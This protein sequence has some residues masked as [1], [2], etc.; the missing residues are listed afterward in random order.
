[1]L[2]VL[3]ARRRLSL[4]SAVALVSCA[5]LLSGCGLPR[6]LSDRADP[7]E[8]ASL[9]IC[10]VVP[11]GELRKDHPEV[12]MQPTVSIPSACV[13]R[14]GGDD[15]EDAITVSIVDSDVP[16][17]VRT[18]GGP[19]VTDEDVDG[20]TAVHVDN[21]EYCGS[22][23]L[24]DNGIWL[25]IGP[26]QSRGEPRAE[27]GCDVAQSIARSVVRELAS[28][29]PMIDWPEKSLFRKDICARAEGVELAPS[30]GV[31][32]E[33]TAH[34]THLTCSYSAAGSD[35][36]P[37]NG[38]VVSVVIRGEWREPPMPDR[39]RLT[40]AGHVA[41]LDDTQAGGSRPTGGALCRFEIDFGHNPEVDRRHRSDDRES[42]S[43]SLMTRGPYG[44][45]S[46]LPAIT[47]LVES[48]D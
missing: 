45:E 41:E 2:T 33:V 1:M 30:L 42:L 44:C 19:G 5:L 3:Y 15:D 28:A 38:L 8:Y 22:Y 18:R 6:P 11:I 36:G 25:G 46:A 34:P 14:L 23:A 13:I 35:P 31:D 47:E 37:I 29:T 24:S 17:A 10:G 21:D 26:G 27:Q 16:E 39:K 20:G 43:I 12:E 9:D 40:I 32:A 7:Q 4:V 48:L